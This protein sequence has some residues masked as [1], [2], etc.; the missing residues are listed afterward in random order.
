DEYVVSI[1]AK[2]SGGPY[3]STV[4]RSLI[5]SAKRV[6]ADYSVDIYPFY[7]SDVEASLRAG[8]DVRFGLIGPGVEASH[9]YERT[10]YKALENTLKL[11]EGY[12]GN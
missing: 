3:D 12:V 9:G 4:V 6:G 1:C 7:G 2:D 5:E 10:H 8:Y 11:I